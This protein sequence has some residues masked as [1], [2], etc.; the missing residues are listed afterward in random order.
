MTQATSR[1]AVYNAVNGV[2]DVGKVYDYLRLSTEW[3][4]DDF[5]NL[6]LINIGGIDQIRGWM[7]EYRGFES[8]TLF[9]CDIIRRH[10]FAINGYNRIND[11]RESEKE[12][13]TLAETVTNALDDDAT[14]HAHSD[15]GVS[16]LATFEVRMFGQVA[17]HYAEIIQTITEQV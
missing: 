2:T 4:D 13:S 11:K 17:C 14:V 15:T 9:S 16:Q 3:S 10:T 1:T 7:V 12:F 8:E 6:F 5:L